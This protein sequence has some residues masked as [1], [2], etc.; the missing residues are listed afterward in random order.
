MNLKQ[1][2]EWVAEEVNGKPLTFSSVALEGSNALTDPF[3]RKVVRGVQKVYMDVLM[4]S[5]FWTFLNK[6]GRLLTIRSGISQYTM[7]DNQSLEWDSLYLTKDGTAARWPVIR[8][9]YDDWQRRER[10]V[11]NSTG[12]PLRVT[13]GKT[14]SEILFWPVPNDTYYLNGNAQITP[15]PL[16]EAD[17]KPVWDDNFH[18]LLVWLAV[19]HL[20]SRVRTKEEIVSQLNSSNAQSNATARYGAF[21][22]QYLPPILSA[23]KFS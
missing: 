20:E 2:C 22:A 14:L 17:D 23:E 10:S 4:A 5:R 8:E 15:V 19:V 18:D 9:T 11:T 7:R 21:C 3:Q 1:L 13:T 12:I 16:V 6:R